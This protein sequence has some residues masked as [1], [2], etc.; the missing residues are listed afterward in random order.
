MGRAESVTHESVW[1]E[2]IFLIFFW[3]SLASLSI[4]MR[5]MPSKRNKKG[6]LLEYHCAPE[7]VLMKETRNYFLFVSSESRGEHENTKTP[8]TRRER[9]MFKIFRYFFLR[10]RVINLSSFTATLN[11]W[12]LNVAEKIETKKKMLRER[13]KNWLIVSNFCSSRTTRS[14]LSSPLGS[15]D[16]FE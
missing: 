9:K 1:F 2:V 13:E 4:D 15:S 12:L 14:L 11:D 5:S 6:K 16:K 7:S 8:D 3:I 10:K